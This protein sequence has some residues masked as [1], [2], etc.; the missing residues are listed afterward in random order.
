MFL[1]GGTAGA[2]ART[3]TAPLD[4]IKL[5]FQVQVGAERIQNLC[6]LG[7]A[8]GKCRQDSSQWQQGQS[9]VI[10]EMFGG[11]ERRQR[12]QGSCQQV[13]DAC[14]CNYA[15][16]T[17][18]ALHQLKTGQL[19]PASMP[20]RP[21]PRPGSAACVSCVLCAAGA[22]GAVLR[23]CPQQ[24]HGAA[25]GRPQDIQ[26]GHVG[27]GGRST[28]VDAPLASLLPSIPAGVTLSLSH[29]V[30]RCPCPPPALSPCSQ[31]GLA[32]FWKGNGVNI[33]R[34]FPYSAAQLAANDTYKRALAT[35]TGDPGD[36]VTQWVGGWVDR[37]V[38]LS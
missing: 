3:A 6:W 36:W 4:R 38:V 21:A 10:P 27:A 16:A 9:A 23:R 11:S 22:G 15:Q 29:R 18:S 12:L 31:E 33:L 37:L 19:V 13:Q 8:S 7:T 30:A 5:L 20:Q 2:I 32:A 1:A 14:S 25:A 26:V 35:P 17:S 34:I 28:A 24:L